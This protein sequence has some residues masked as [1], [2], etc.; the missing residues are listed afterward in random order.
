M[1]LEQK[2][3]EILIQNI[4]Y[5]EVFCNEDASPF[6]EI[7]IYNKELSFKIYTLEKDIVLKVN[8]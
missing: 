5:L 8:S 1:T 4:F 6:L 7:A 3:S 2:K